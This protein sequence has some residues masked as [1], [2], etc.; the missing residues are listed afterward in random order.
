VEIISVRGWE[1]VRLTT[2]QVV[3]EVVP[4]LGGTLTSVRR[5]RDD[6]ELLWQTPWGLRP[7]YDR[8]AS[9]D[10]RTLRWLADPGGWKS[11]FP[12]AGEATSMHG[13]EWA[14]DGEAW[15]TPFDHEIS[16]GGSL[17]MTSRLV[18]APFEL[19]RVVSV[20]DDTVSVGET[21]RNVGGVAIEVVWASQLVFGAPL[22]SADA[23]LDCAANL[24]HPD[25]EIV[26]DASYGDIMPWPRSQGRSGMINLHTLLGPEAEEHRLVYLDEL[27]AGRLSVENRTLDL[28]V[29]LDWDLTAWPYVIYELEAGGSSG[30]P[31]FD[32]GYFLRIQPS[33]SWPAKGLYDARRLSS[34]TIWVDP[35]QERSAHLDLRVHDL[36]P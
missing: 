10:T 7:P 18:R 4:G 9:G 23:T 34:S 16:D 21:I 14:E 3:V 13:T 15:L 17:I 28:R 36:A 26:S 22:L 1:V 29:E 19:R 24:V 25:P 5:R 27:D 32:R 6:L 35:G 8:S 11:I 12:N 33:T 2:D 20:H 31:F 30:F